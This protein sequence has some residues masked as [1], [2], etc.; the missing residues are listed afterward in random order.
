MNA[1]P[2]RS[3]HPGPTIEAG[4]AN[5]S[6][7]AQARFDG[8]IAFTSW[9]HADVEALLPAELELVPSVRTPGEHPVAFIL[10][11]QTDCAVLIGGFPVPTGARYHEVGMMV[12]FVKHRQGR[13]VH[14]YVPRMYASYFPAVWSGNLNFGFAKQLATIS[15]HGH[16]LLVTGE[17]GVPLL[18]ADVEPAGDWLPGAS[19]RLENFDAM[20]AAFALPVVGR[21][22]DGTL[23]CSYFGW[24]F[25][26]TFVR[27]GDSCIVIHQP[28]VPGLAPQRRPDVPAGSFEV[29]GLLWQLSWPAR[30][31]F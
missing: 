20:R 13:H 1:F 22:N 25:A 30:C 19:C 3:A 6:F 12:P 2:V 18:E 15:R 29:R 11:E 10:G 5:A 17:G 21:R 8:W 24:G 14:I 4:V 27:P 23:V 9:P 26:D 28:L 7:V 31:R 16:V